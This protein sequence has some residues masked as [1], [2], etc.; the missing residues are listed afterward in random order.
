MVQYTLQFQGDPRESCTCQI[1][2]PAAHQASLQ[3]KVSCYLGCG[4]PPVGTLCRDRE[5][6]G[7]AQGSTCSH[8]SILYGPHMLVQIKFTSETKKQMNTTEIMK[9]H[10]EAGLVKCL[11]G[12]VQA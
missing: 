11:Y 1:E 9:L 7:A 6:S 5:T 4:E 2:Y 10:R 3:G 12:E 8:L